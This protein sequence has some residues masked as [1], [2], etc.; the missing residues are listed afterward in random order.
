MKYT[1]P[2]YDEYIDDFV[3]LITIDRMNEILEDMYKKN[4]EEYYNHFRECFKM[5]ISRGSYEKVA[6]EK[7]LKT[8]NFRNEV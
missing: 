8:F 7:K 5:E 3:F 1:P 4:D 6:G 2:K